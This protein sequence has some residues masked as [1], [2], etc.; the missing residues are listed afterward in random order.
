[1]QWK[2][3]VD[4]VQERNSDLREANIRYWVCQLDLGKPEDTKR[5]SYSVLDV[6]KILSKAEKGE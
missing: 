2:E 5:K 1:M 6:K 4:K 3:L